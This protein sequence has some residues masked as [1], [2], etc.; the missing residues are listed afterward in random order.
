[1][2]TGMGQM[3][4]GGQLFGAAMRE[5]PYPIYKQLRQSDPV[6]WDDSLPAW[7]LTR[8][9]DV[10]LALK[11]PRFS[12]R[13]VAHARSRFPDPSL[14]PLFDTLAGRMSDHDPPDHQRLRALVHDA[15]IRTSVQQWTPRITARIDLLLA[16]AEQRG[17]VDFIA[18]F[19]IPLPLLAIL[20][21][22]GIPATDRQRVKN[23]CDDFA[24]VALNFFAHISAQDLQR[25][26]RSIMEFRQ[27]LGERMGELQGSSRSDLLS[28]LVQAEHEGSRLSVDELLANT[29]LLL[30]A[31][32]ETTTCVL[33]NGLGALLQHPDQL[34]L[35]RSNP[36]L[37]PAAV[38]EFLRFDSPV[39]FLGR[40]AVDDI[41][42]G[43]ATIHRGDLVLAVLAAANRDPARFADPDRFDVT[44][45]P[46]QHVAFG[47]G[48][49]FC[50]GAQLA[51]LE[52][53]LA[54]AALLSRFA[55][56]EL[57]IDA[58]LVHR[59]NFNIRCWETLPVRLQA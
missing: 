53:Q 26:L 47:H 54:I 52:T 39:Q 40:I 6:Y 20:E 27:Y 14:A 23:W 57:D 19:A 1:M 15:F 8:Y 46:V 9:E 24:V 55:S 13:R 2:K 10:A 22:V 4:N 29:L 58:P 32:N 44:R 5:D 11:D 35:L 41:S 38:E 56:I 30:A 18:D 25:G 36:A 31:G 43:G 51:R 42:L 12:S 50:V 48:P 3:L 16:A 45:S 21:I 28:S 49:H 37:I 59:E 34:E 7:I 33:G 17:H